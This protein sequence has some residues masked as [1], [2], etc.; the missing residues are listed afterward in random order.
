MRIANRI[1]V[2]ALLL[3]VVAAMTAGTSRAQNP[4]DEL[5]NWLIFNSTIRFSDQWSLFTEGHLRLW[6][7]ASNLNEWLVRATGHYNFNPD[8]MVGFGYV[9]AVSYP[10]DGDGRDRIENRLYQQFAL[11][12][13]W[14]RTRFEHRYRLEQRWLKTDETRFSNR[15][16]YRL[17]VT[18]PLN[19]ETIQPGAYFI[20]TFNE[21][22]I[23]FD[24]GEREFN[25]NR[26]YVAGGHQFTP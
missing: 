7:V 20:N 5:G 19:H 22:F 6:E 9:R 18:I 15:V 12:Q 8:A 24:G 26:L 14:G 13:N 4:E 3:A 23:N 10:F 16:R 21:T 25:Q 11:W 1:A 17:Q 2:A